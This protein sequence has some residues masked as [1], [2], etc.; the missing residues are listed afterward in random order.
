MEIL[1]ALVGAFIG[2]IV[3][4]Y[5]SGRRQKEQNRISNEQQRR[6]NQIFSEQQKHQNKISMTLQIYEQYESSEMAMARSRVV[7]LLKKCLG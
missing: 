3:T 7:V 2:A 1:T 6:Q 4:S 5:F